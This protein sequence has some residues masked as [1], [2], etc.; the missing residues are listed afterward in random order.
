MRSNID[1][2]VRNKWQRETDFVIEIIH[3]SR[4][5]LDIHVCRWMNISHDDDL[6]GSR[7]ITASRLSTECDSGREKLRTAKWNSIGSIGAILDAIRRT[8]RL[9]DSFQAI[10]RSRNCEDGRVY[11]SDHPD[12][13]LY[14]GFALPNAER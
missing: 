11:G 2:Y 12:R 9:R 13:F 1:E 10:L 8:G 3:R 5:F 14:Q 6:L 4:E 7:V